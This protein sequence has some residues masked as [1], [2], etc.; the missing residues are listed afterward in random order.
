VACGTGVAA[1]EAARRVGSQGSVI[2]LDRNPDMLAVAARAA[3]DIDWRLG[4]AE[5]L[6]FDD[7][8][9][10]VVI[11]QFGLMFFDDRVAALKDMMRVLKPNGRLVVAVWDRL[12]RSPGYA[13]VT[14]LLERLFDDRIA[15]AMRAPFVLGETDELRSL[16][17]SAGIEDA[18]ISSQ[19]GTARFPSIE[20]WVH[21]DVKGWTLADL[22]DD[23]QYE[24][25][26]AES[27]RALAPFRQDDGTVAFAAPAHLVTAVK[28]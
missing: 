16:F 5:D 15:D 27:L 25:L 6:P 13:A 12:E 28:P 20:A 4:L 14:A 3:P 7:A 11:S 26:Q 23:E 18:R 10:D 21:T 2:G 8:T 1:R 17:A 24:R 22:I 9:F 19:D